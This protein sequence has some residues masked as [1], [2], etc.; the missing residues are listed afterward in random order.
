MECLVC[1]HG[2]TKPGTTTV[3]LERNALTLVTKGVPAQVCDNCTE[4][5]VDGEIAEQLLITAE[6]EAR[7]GVRVQVREYGAA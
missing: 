6:E 3:T 5:Y 4:T 7:R 1:R 2:Q